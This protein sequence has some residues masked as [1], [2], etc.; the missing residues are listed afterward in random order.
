MLSAM[1]DLHPGSA[2]T[3]RTVA[4]SASAVDRVF[5]LGARALACLTASA[6]AALA[7]PESPIRERADFPPVMIRGDGILL[8]DGKPFFPV[9]LVDIGSWLPLYANDWNQRIRDSHA[10]IVW[11]IQAAYADTLPT[12]AALI[13]SANAA[14]YKLLIGSGDT[15]LWDDLTTPELEVDQR[16][17]EPE[18]LQAVLDCA[19][20]SPGT[21]IGFANRDEPV[22][23][24]SRGMIGDI[25][26][27]HIRDTYK[28]IHTAVDETIVAM[29]FA[30][31]HLSLDLET[32]KDDVRSYRTA[33]DVMLF[34][35]YPFPAGPG[36]CLQWNVLG[37]PDCPMDRLPIS[38]DIFLSE[39]NAPG[40]PLWM[41]V[42]G[43]KGIQYKEARWEAVAAIVHGA[44]GVLWA[45]WPWTHA[46]GNG[47]DSW[48]DVSRCI[49]DIESLHEYLVGFDVTGAATDDPDVEA[50][51]KRTSGTEVAVFAISRNEFS[52]SASIYLPRL[53]N[54]GNAVVQVAHEDRH[55]TAVDGWIVD[56]FDGY[57]AHVYTY[58]GSF[59]E[60]QQATGAPEF[61]GAPRLSIA[62]HPNPSR[63]RTVIS[64]ELDRPAALFFPVYDAAGRRVSVVARGTFDA[65][66]GQ[67]TWNGRDASGRPVAAGVY[68]I[69]ARSS[70]G[71][72]AA[73]RVLLR[74]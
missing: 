54:G 34:A 37:W 45:G 4:T 28:Q 53:P 15:W 17:Y 51:A 63:G 14:G 40:Q 21:V 74:P 30:P 35:S 52:G 59:I 1:T 23:T 27:Q 65:G 22:W 69:H 42:Q 55:L 5:R 8:L 43:H 44:T 33:T 56:H 70:D 3:P 61:D 16:M 10:N 62:A 26:E 50:R 46:L 64:F 73:T 18:E 49:R 36:T 24:I 68:F 66:P 72:E 71:R 38:A 57:Q 25:D 6:T 67:V 19:S 9:G 2:A 47:W 41:I 48:D 29:N 20:E 13:D 60:G 32:W 7:V 31:A 39:L 11:D 58:S 12:C